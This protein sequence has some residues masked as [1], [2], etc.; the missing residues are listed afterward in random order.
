MDNSDQNAPLDQSLVDSRQHKT[1]DVRQASKAGQTTVSNPP[2]FLPTDEGTG[3]AVHSKGNSVHLGSLNQVT[4]PQV[5]PEAAHNKSPYP[6]PNTMGSVPQFPG[7]EGLNK[8][9]NGPEAVNTMMQQQQQQQQ[10]QQFQQQ[11]MLAHTQRMQQEA[12][13]MGQ[14]QVVQG[15]TNPQALLPGMAAMGQMAGMK[16]PQSLGALH[17]QQPQNPQQT[18]MGPNP[19]MMQQ[20]SMPGHLMPGQPMPG[21][22]MPGQPMPGHPMH[23]QMQGVPGMHPG[24]GMQGMPGML[25]Q[26]MPGMPMATPMAG[27]P[28]AVLQQMLMGGMFVPLR[29]GKWTP[30]EEVYVDKI[31]QCFNDGTLQAPPGVTLRAYLSKQLHCDPMRITKKFSGT[32]SIGKRMFTPA[33]LNN[34]PEHKIKSDRL[35]LHILEM[36]WRLQMETAELTQKQRQAMRNP[37]FN[38]KLKEQFNQHSANILQN[39][40]LLNAASQNLENLDLHVKASRPDGNDGAAAEVTPDTPNRSIFKRT[41]SSADLDKVPGSPKQVKAD[42]QGVDAMALLGFMQTVTTE[43]KKDTSET[44]KNHN[45]DSTT[46]GINTGDDSS[47][48]LNSPG[49]ARIED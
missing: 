48:A 45:S 33:S 3:K 30:E 13:Q 15:Q 36:K 34:V 40:K 12:L 31:I 39:F 43:T 7:N 38:T 42:S 32:T 19:M 6:V 49:A 16:Y 10:F 1:T 23:W 46:P 4:G 8:P 29:R 20:H 25:M 21:Q 14:S 47:E 22:P 41:A 44:K 37:Y 17:L 28:P 26:G 5:D 18:P 2:E 24:M 9:Q 27:V 35:Q 11:A